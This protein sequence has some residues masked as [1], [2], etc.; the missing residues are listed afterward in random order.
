MLRAVLLR[1]VIPAASRDTRGDTASLD[2]A[3]RAAS[4]LWGA[5]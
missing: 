5:I 1:A 2:T 3:S 4:E